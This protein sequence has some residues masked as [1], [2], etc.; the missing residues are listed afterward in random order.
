[1]IVIIVVILLVVIIGVVAAL[2]VYGYRN[3]TSTLGQA[4]IKVCTCTCTHS[5]CIRIMSVQ[6]CTRD[7]TELNDYMLR[8]YVLSLLSPIAIATSY[9]L[10][11]C[12][13]PKHKWC[14]CDQQ[15]E[16]E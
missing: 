16:L 14:G 9:Y 7:G 12:G 5:Y 8:L 15:S 6:A 4:M 13:V 3:P 2:L 1:M 11:V 10:R